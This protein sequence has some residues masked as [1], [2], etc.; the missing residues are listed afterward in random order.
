MNALNIALVALFA[1]T[2][3]SLLAVLGD[4]IALKQVRVE[5]YAY[6]PLVKFLRWMQYPSLVALAVFI[7]TSLVSSPGLNLLLL[8]FGTCAAVVY[9]QVNRLPKDRANMSRVFLPV[10]AAT[11][12]GGNLRL[13]PDGLQLPL[14]AVVLA[15]ISMA[16]FWAILELRHQ[17]DMAVLYG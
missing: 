1:A 12:V 6:V 10:V 11:M 7:I 4:G 17:Q 15:V 3:L 9:R 5:R 13:L 16:A 2:S 14:L 8:V